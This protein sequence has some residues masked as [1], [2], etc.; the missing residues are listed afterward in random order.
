M[1]YLFNDADQ[2]QGLTIQKIDW[3]LK[4]VKEKMLPV[5]DPDGCALSVLSNVSCLTVFPS[6]DTLKT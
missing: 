5:G 1:L 4:T 6:I 3:K 2:F